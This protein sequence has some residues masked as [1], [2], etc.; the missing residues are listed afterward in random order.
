MCN[1][2]FLT[3]I[4]CCL[5]LLFGCCS[6]SSEKD[7]LDV[8]HINVKLGLLYL[9]QGCSTV[10]KGKLLLAAEQA[11]H[12]A[13]VHAAMGYF[14]SHM[15]EAKVAEKHYLYSIKLA[16]EKGWFWHNYG[17]FLYLQGLNQQALTYFLCAAKDFHYLYVAE[18]YSDASL[19]AWK[20]NLNELAEKYHVAAVSHGF[21]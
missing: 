10:A 12:D 5:F 8:A 3:L 15:G 4:F 20:L 17:K 21:H 7:K 6:I 14:F 16:K 2:R 18:A 1:F 11:P 9:Q 13:E 19:A